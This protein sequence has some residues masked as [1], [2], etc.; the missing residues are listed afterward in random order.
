MGIHYAETYEIITEE[1][2]IDGDAEERGFIDTDAETDFR[3][4]SDLLQGTEPSSSEI[5]ISGYLTWYTR[6]ED[7][8]YRTGE[9]KNRSYHPKT[10]RDARWM[11]KAWKYAN[12]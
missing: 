11:K 8:D 5:S 3:N 10:E 4:M 12:K 2:A 7:M 9:W 1:S 6:Y